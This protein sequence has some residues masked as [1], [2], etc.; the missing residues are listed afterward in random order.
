MK[1]D[2]RGRVIDFGRKIIPHNAKG[3]PAFGALG[4]EDFMAAGGDEAW[5]VVKPSPGSI[6]EQFTCEEITA[7]VNRYLYQQEYQRTAHRRRQRMQAEAEEPLKKQ[8]ERMF[9][10][11]WTQATPEQ[12]EKAG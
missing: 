11:R 4:C 7:M 2:A 6:L 10:I 8:I 9:N 12:I 5:R 3:D 1:E